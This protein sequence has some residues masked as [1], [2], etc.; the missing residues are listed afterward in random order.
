MEDCLD[1][2]DVFETLDQWRHLP[3]YQLERRA[4][5]FFAMYLPK[6][7]EEHYGVELMPLI[8]EFPLRLG[9]LWPSIDSSK[10]VK[11]DYV[12]V[13]KDRSTAYFVELKTDVG[14]RRDSQDKYLTRSKELGFHPLVQGV[15]DIFVASPY[16]A[17]YFHLISMLECQGLVECPSDLA[18]YVY[19]KPRSGLTAKKRGVQVMCPPDTSVEVLYLQPVGDG[20]DILNFETYADWLTGRGE[21]ADVF[22]EYL[23]RWQSEAAHAAP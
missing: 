15:A 6:Y 20:D 8:P 2:R 7:L 14:S 23:V 10:S 4:D 5:I 17:K 21:M 16:H 12:A 13:A 19:P 22:A 18:D 3:A 11:V 1:I 9:A